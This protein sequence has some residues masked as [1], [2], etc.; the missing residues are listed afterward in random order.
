MVWIVVDDRKLPT[1]RLSRLSQMAR[2]GAR[3]GLALL[4]KGDGSAA[5]E[6]AAQLLGNLRG[7]ATKVGQMASYVD[8]FVPPEQSAAY[9]RALA[10]LQSATPSS[11]FSQVRALLE[12]ELGGTLEARFASFEQRPFASA[13]IGQV[14][15]ARLHDG[16]EVAVKV[17]HPDIASALEADLGSGGAIASMVALLG[18][19]TLSPDAI[20]REIAARFREELDYALEARRQTQYRELYSG[21]SAIHIP[22][23]VASHSSRRVLTSEF[24][25]GLDFEAATRTQPAIRRRYAEVLWRFVFSNILVHHLFNA[26]PH[27][28]NYLF[29]EDGRVTFLD[30]GC[31][32]E[33]PTDY[34]AAVRDMHHAALR[35]DE[36]SFRAAL[37]SGL[38]TLPGAYEE[39][40]CQYLWRCFAP[41]QSSPFHIQHDYVSQVVRG[42]FDLKQHMLNKRSNPTPTAPSVMLLNRLQFGFY[43][44]RARLDVEADYAAVDRAILEASTPAARED[45]P[46][47]E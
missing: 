43:S 34:V 1:G 38:Q 20:F 25:H 2:V 15:R 32:Q 36:A 31:M 6:H 16:R 3:S 28:G 45:H 46:P 4:G 27:P 33:L 42:I 37:R 14:H 22:Y 35:R 24:V 47:S 23:V 40:L 13:S 29:H 19:R 39:Q 11:P 26:D 18:P 5:A 9:A 41:L 17:Q 10:G 21:D 30:F 7:L 44:V 12:A 8:G